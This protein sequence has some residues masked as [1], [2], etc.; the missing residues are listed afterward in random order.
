VPEDLDM[1]VARAL[2]KEP[3]DRYQSAAAMDSDLEAVARGGHVPVETIEAATMVLGAGAVDTTAAT[4][5]RRPRTGPDI[6][7]DFDPMRRRKR[8]LWPW[9][10]GAGAALA[11][12]VLGFLLYPWVSDQ[13]SGS[14]QV[15]VPYVVALQ[16][17]AARAEITERGLVPRV[18][19]ISSSDV[20]EGVVIAQRPQEGT[21]VDKGT[22]VVIDV[23]SGRPEV[24]VPSVVGQSRD[25]AV[26]EL[27]DAGLDAQVA[28][29]SSDKEEGTVTG[30]SPAP[31]TVVVEGTRVRINV[32]TGPKPVSVP[33]VV[34]LPYDE[35][36]SELRAD[37]FGV[38]RVNVPSELAAG[39]VVD[40]NPAGGTQSDRGTTV[41]LSVSEG[42]STREVPDVTNQDVSVARAT[43]QNNGFR[44][45]EVPENVDDPAM[46]GIVTAQDPPGFAEAEPGSLVTIFV[47]TFTPQDTTDTTAPPS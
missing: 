15:A 1:V 23:S 27:T 44:V 36:A 14:D 5:V 42:P 38:S 20:D 46:E 22:Q 24:E 4:Q 10:A 33:N 2:A 16:E 13:L 17:A 39:V 40:Q 21:D 37:G 35:A 32:S 12:L 7:P 11:I 47:G 19:R 28:E 30:Q 34:G 29:V 8:P 6:P 18:R 31:G 41:E 3:K 43:L 26:A 45:R 25:S 9:L